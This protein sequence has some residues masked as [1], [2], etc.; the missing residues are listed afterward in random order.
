MSVAEAVEDMGERGS[1]RWLEPLI[2]ESE[3]PLLVSPTQMCLILGVKYTRLYRWSRMPGFAPGAVHRKGH[4][5]LYNWR[6]VS[7][8]VDEHLDELPGRLDLPA[9]P[10]R[11]RT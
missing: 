8:F 9:K 1:P 5:V 4:S 6:R 10:K 2:P 11:K 3:R 7:Q